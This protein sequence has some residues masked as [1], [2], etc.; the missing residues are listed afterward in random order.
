MR[1]YDGDDMGEV[2]SLAQ[3]MDEMRQEMTEAWEPSKVFAHAEAEYRRGY[4][5]GYIMAVE[6]F[7]DFMLDFNL[8]RKDAYNRLFDFAN[9]G[10]L[11]E[12]YWKAQDAG[13]A[14]T[15]LPPIPTSE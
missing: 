4:R 14:E 2:V 15:E 11:Y 6:R 5:D 12:W 7:I 13:R 1:K 10:A 8:S 3:L 9:H